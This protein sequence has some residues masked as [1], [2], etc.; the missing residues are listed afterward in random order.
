MHNT[1]ARQILYGGAVGGGKSHGIRWDAYAFCLNND[2][3]QAYLFR[4]SYE[5]LR[6][7]HI[8]FVQWEIPAQL[9]SYKETRKAFEF[10]NGST[11][12]FCYC[13]RE[14]DVYR[15]QGAEMHWIG[16][17]EAG[18]MTDTMLNYLKTR[19]RLGGWVP[20][21]DKRRL[22]RFVMG[23]NPGGPGHNYLKSI[24][25]DSGPPETIFFDSTMRDP[26][27]P[28]DKGWSSIFIPAKMEDNKYIDDDY[29]SALGGLPPELAKAYREGDWDA[30]VGA[31]LHN[32]SRDRHLVRSFKIP[33]HWTKF[34]AIDW[35]TA[36][37][38]SVG[39]YAV[40]E[41]AELGEK[42]G[43]RAVWMPAG[44]VIRYDEWYGWDG[45]PNHGCRKPAQE[46]A[47]GIRERESNRGEVMDYRIGD[48]EMWAQRGGPSTKDW[49]QKEGVILRK[50]QKDRARNYSEIIAR[51][52]GHPEPGHDEEEHPMFFVTENCR[53]FW[54]T[55][56]SLVLDQTDPEKGPDTKLEDHVYDEVAYALRSRPFVTTEED[57]YMAEWGDQIRQA[58]GGNADPYSTR[59][60]R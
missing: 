17:D 59:A 38:F 35:G 1:T 6:D 21:N 44:A 47:R 58:R 51:L 28:D 37:P 46:V 45:R 52:G 55:C 20:E 56:P 57:R 34:Q 50:S 16:I 30:V 15:Y 49:F 42:E 25:L 54:R 13:E 5:E 27:N 22:P 4:R 3:C 11:L 9:G 24:F 43:Y 32:L 48:T 12:H 19:N 53:H 26:S 40:S 10:K 60:Q 36:A 8:K 23:S 14:A 39:W 41:G 33:P 29:A 7:N 2:R 18:Q 31:A